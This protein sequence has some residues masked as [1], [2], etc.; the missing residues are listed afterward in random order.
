MTKARKHEILLLGQDI[1]QRIQEL[2]ILA[3][4][5][6]DQANATFDVEF[7]RIWWARHRT[8]VLSVRLLENSKRLLGYA[9]EGTL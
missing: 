5:M 3:D 9:I 1:D 8:I 6:T 4:R 2:N 7:K